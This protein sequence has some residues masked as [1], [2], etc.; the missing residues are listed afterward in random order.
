V[1]PLD[2]VSH[3]YPAVMWALM[4]W[5][6]AHTFL[7]VIMQLYCLAGS[8]WGKMTPRYDADL[9][10]TTLFWHFMVLTALVTGFILGVAPRM[11]P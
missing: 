6:V 5:L 3:V 1:L 11:M 8:I 4:V 2:P 10:N 9:C 7:G